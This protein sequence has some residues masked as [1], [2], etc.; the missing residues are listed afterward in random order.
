MSIDAAGTLAGLFGVWAI[1]A[2][3]AVFLLVPPAP[4][5][6]TTA[7]ATGA[8]AQGCFGRHQKS[9]YGIGSNRSLK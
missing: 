7:A 4:G 8:K 1:V 3:G 6:P 5:S 2:S 9:L